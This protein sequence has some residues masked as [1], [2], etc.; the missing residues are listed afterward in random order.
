MF[1]SLLVKSSN[2]PPEHPQLQKK[3]KKI[4]LPVY[5]QQKTKH[6]IKI[7]FLIFYWCVCDFSC[8]FFYSE[9]IPKIIRYISKYHL[10]IL[11]KKTT[12]QLSFLFPF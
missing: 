11:S 2:H 8:N 7:F 1:V 5:R 10:T 9:S 4:G 12:I 6:N 3:N